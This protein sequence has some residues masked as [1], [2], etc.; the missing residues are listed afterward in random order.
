MPQSPRLSRRLFIHV[1][2][3]G[4]QLDARLT[5]VECSFSQAM[6]NVFL[7]LILLIIFV[8]LFI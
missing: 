5:S 1:D 4:P 6:Q 7:S 2:Y 3:L 8:N